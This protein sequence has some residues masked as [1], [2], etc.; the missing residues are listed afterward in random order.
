MKRKNSI[1]N[2]IIVLGI[3]LFLASYSFGQIGIST[4]SPNPAAEL[5]IESPNNNTGVLI[6]SLTTSEINDPVAFP[7][8]THGMLIYNST[9][10][11]FMYN[12]GISSAPVWTNVGQ[13]PAV[14]NISNE[15]CSAKGEIRYCKTNKKIFYC[16]GS[17]WTMLKSP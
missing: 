5:D 4:M 8:P 11:A 12:S 2:K 10:K 16:N 3:L 7:N 15:T 14:A 13:V 1:Y 17:S 9:E 6:P